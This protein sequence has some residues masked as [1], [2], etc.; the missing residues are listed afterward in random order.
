MNNRK[1]RYLERRKLMSQYKVND[2]QA[3]LGRIKA[4]VLI[5]WGEFC[6]LKPSEADRFKAWLTAA[7]TVEIKVYANVGHL[8]FTDAGERAARDI[9]DFAAEAGV[10]AP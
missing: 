4:P 7:R 8:L 5:L 3:V 9:R 2:S 6:E 10:V 1:D